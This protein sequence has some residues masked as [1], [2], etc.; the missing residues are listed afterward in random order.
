[1]SKVVTAKKR[2]CKS[3]PRCKRCP[4]VLK[5]LTAAGLAEHVGHRRYELDPSIGRRQMKAARRK[6]KK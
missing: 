4:V 2:C 3:G 5:R 6:A 1:M